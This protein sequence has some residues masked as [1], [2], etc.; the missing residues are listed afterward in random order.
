M[1]IV[2]KFNGYSHDVR[3]QKGVNESRPILT[4]GLSIKEV[5]HKNDTIALYLLAYLGFDK[6]LAQIIDEYISLFSIDVRTFLPEIQRIRNKTNHE[7][8]NNDK[9]Y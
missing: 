4:F 5:I 9:N 1:T 7:E 2:P 8:Y 3:I 6:I